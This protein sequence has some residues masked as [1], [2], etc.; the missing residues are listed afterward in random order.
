MERNAI[1]DFIDNLIVEKNISKN[2]AND[3]QEALEISAKDIESSRIAGFIK[4]VQ[5]RMDAPA[6]GVY[7]RNGI[8]LENIKLIIE[9]TAVEVKKE[10]IA[11][12][13]NKRVETEKDA[14]SQ[15]EIDSEIQKK[16]N[17]EKK[18]EIIEANTTK[19]FEWLED[20]N[21]SSSATVNLS[22][23][24]RMAE[25]EIIMDKVKEAKESGASDE[26]IQKLIDNEMTGEKNPAETAMLEAT[27]LQMVADS[28]PQSSKDSVE[29]NSEEDI[30][31]ENPLVQRI[32]KEK[33][34]ELADGSEG[35]YVDE[36]VIEDLSE[37]GISIDITNNIQS[38]ANSNYHGKA[39]NGPFLSW[40][41]ERVQ[42][43]R[44]LGGR[45]D[46]KVDKYVNGILAMPK[47]A[48][49]SWQLLKI[50]SLEKQ[51][52][53]KSYCTVEIEKCEKRISELRNTD[54]D[55]EESLLLEAK[56]EIKER[57]TLLTDTEKRKKIVQMYFENRMPAAK[58]YRTLVDSG[59]IEDISGLIIDDVIDVV[60]EEVK[61]YLSPN[62]VIELMK[63]EQEIEEHFIEREAYGILYINALKKGKRYSA[64]LASEKE[65]YARIAIENLTRK[66]D[67]IR[68]RVMRQKYPSRFTPQTEERPE[69]KLTKEQKMLIARRNKVE[70]MRYSELETEKTYRLMFDAY[71]DKDTDPDNNHLCEA[72][73]R[74][75]IAKRN[76]RKAQK[77]Q[78]IYE[79]KLN[80]RD[81]VDTTN[82]LL[83]DT[84]KRNKIVELYFRGRKS[85]VEIY[86]ELVKTGEI[87]EDS[88]LLTDDVIDVIKDEAEKHGM[89]PGEIS[90][91][92]ERE[93]ALEE[94][95]VQA[96]AYDRIYNNATKIRNRDC[97]N[98]A[99]VKRNAF[100]DSIRKISSDGDS[101]RRRVI[102]S[103]LKSDSQRIGSELSNTQITRSGKSALRVEKMQVDE[104]RPMLFGKDSFKGIM[105]DTK[106]IVSDDLSEQI[107]AI[108][109]LQDKHKIVSNEEK[110]E[111]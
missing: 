40:E 69:K 57:N 25:A 33:E 3:L 23:A 50:T 110:G 29:S 26:E 81:Y 37:S 109:L 20:G 103:Q 16:Q 6:S 107:R 78:L 75:M 58:I 64:D 31:L 41:Q 18:A 80:D 91:M 52:Q 46:R 2:D 24:K 89:T 108:K 94:K 15:K 53:S 59:E 56:K 11:F 21:G 35:Y 87:P 76:A 60:A 47:V 42:K 61:E 72:M 70:E 74:V 65:G 10:Q 43:E 105:M 97:A 5:Q 45:R 7:T 14:K 22:T 101:F 98:R 28:I 93:E 48:I 100:N 104:Q 96:I 68:E 85:A 79:K 77:I 102:Q 111:Q 54:Y 55:A 90:M 34:V 39:Q 83:T 19:Y 38:Q 86:E 12:Q 82:T 67:E 1:N 84:D 66:G 9:K 30:V 13:E 92:Q 36:Q 32:L 8:N 99:F 73:K 95:R 63:R 4:S 71:K 106:E 51:Y 88:Y 44:T 49:S 27:I 17:D 62:E